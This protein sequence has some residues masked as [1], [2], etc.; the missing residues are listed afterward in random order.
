[1][2]KRHK[3][4]IEDFKESLNKPPVQNIHAIDKSVGI[5]ENERCN[6][7]GCCGV[8]SITQRPCICHIAFLV[9]CSSCEDAHL[10]CDV[11]GWEEDV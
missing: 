8:L 3:E 9:P 11:C 6:R 2:S 1:M 10:W 7:K 4:L 5:Y